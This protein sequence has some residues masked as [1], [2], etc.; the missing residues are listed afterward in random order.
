M[1]AI[2]VGLAFYFNWRRRK[3]LEELAVSMG[4]EFSPEGPEQHELEASGLEIF[5]LGRGRKASNL[6]KVRGGAGEIRVF[7]Y[8]YTIGGGKSSQ[9]HTF[10]LAL[11]AN[12]RCE[13]PQFELKPETFLYKIGEA[14]GF[15]DIDLPAFPDFSDKYRLTGPDEAAVH[16]FFT[17]RRAAWFEANP[18]LWAQGAPCHVV[19]FKRVGHLPVSAWQSFIEE[20]KT[21]AAEI[22]R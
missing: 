22:L 7:D 4:L 11:M 17:P 14:I 9:T 10:T 5:R 2:I 12:L 8:R 15:K 16:M 19:F 3:D 13:V 1:A 21:F 6:I 20:A 18:G